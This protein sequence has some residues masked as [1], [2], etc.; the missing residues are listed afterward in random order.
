MN[1]SVHRWALAASLLIFAGCAGGPPR[2]PE[3]ATPAREPTLRA[4]DIVRLT[5]WREEDMSGEFPVNQSGRVVLPRVG[6]WDVSEETEESLEARLRETLGRE[7]RNPSI[8]V[9][10]LRRIRVVG[11][12]TTPGLYPLDRTMTL[13][14]A[15]ALAGGV[16]REGQRGEVELIRSGERYTV[17]VE[18]YR[19]LSDLSLQSGDVLFVPER[20]WFARNYGV[21]ATAIASVGGLA[22]VIASSVNR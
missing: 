6:E 13:G 12:V 14:D 19:T 18:N 9:A 5:V 1:T 8:D 2:L 10:V 7:L 20:N 16:S 21:L 15:L 17:P 22:V 11:A 3:Q 4:G